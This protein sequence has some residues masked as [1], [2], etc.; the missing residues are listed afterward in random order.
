MKYRS[1]LCWCIISLLL[2]GHSIGFA[3][4]TEKPPQRN[5][6]WPTATPSSAG[7]N[8]A[9]LKQLDSALLA[10]EFEQINS[11]LIACNGTLVYEQYYN[12]YTIDSLHNTRS[13]T[14]SIT[15][16]LIGLAIQQQLIPSEKAAVLP[17]FRDKKP[18]RHPDS[19]KEEITI[20]DLLTM[21]SLL[22]CDDFNQYSRGNE[23][24]MYLIED[25]VRFYLDL[26]IKGFAEWTSK[27]ADSPYGRSFSYCT[28]GVVVLGGVLEKTTQLKVDAFARQY[29]FAPLG[30]NN[31]RW[32]YTPLGLPMTGGGL[33]LS[34]RDYLKLAQL[35]L[36]KGSWQGKEIISRDWVEKSTRP[37]ASYMPNMEY[38]YLFWIGEFGPQDR[39]YT[40]YYMAGAGGNKIAVIPEL[41]LAVVLSSTLF[42]QGGAHQ[43]TEEILNAYIIPAVGK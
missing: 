13:A 43:Q 16:M 7:L 18:L 24:R 1:L 23:E 41:D 9:V 30:I 39:K 19:R 4:Q 27:P 36:N 37:Y 15:G 10:G 6:Q 12:G 21:S 26:P 35:Y 3:Q 11:V 34:S 2:L 40:T 33:Q 25:W 42:G 5:D 32:Q 17:Y 38:G 28:A 20:E 31:Y 22:E 8:A 29:L 14:K